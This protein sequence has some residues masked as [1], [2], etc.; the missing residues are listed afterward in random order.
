MKKEPEDYYC[1]KHG[2]EGNPECS[3]CWENL[4]RLLEDKN[5]FVTGDTP[6]NV[7][8]KNDNQTL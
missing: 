6:F 5:C 8:E 4:F 7:E 3:I 2:G 1:P